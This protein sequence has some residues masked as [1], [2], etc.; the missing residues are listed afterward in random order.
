MKKIFTFV[1]LF[2][3]GLI[4][5]VLPIQGEELT[6]TYLVN[7]TFDE[8]TDLPS[9]LTALNGTTC[10]Y[11]RNGTT[12]VAS[13]V[14]TLS[15][16]AAS[17][18]RGSE[19]WF[20]SSETDSVVYF[21]TDWK[22][23]SATVGN[24]NAF[25]LYLVGSQ[26]SGLT[27]SPT[28]A[29]VILGLYLCGDDAKMHCWNKD[30]WYS[31]STDSIPVFA[32]GSLYPGFTRTASTVALCNDSNL[33]TQTNVA[34]VAGITYHVSAKINFNTKTIDSLT[35]AEKDNELLNGETLT[36]LR[37]INPTTSDLTGL[38]IVNTRSSSKGN[39][40][41][42]T[43]STSFDNLQVYSYKS[44]NSVENQ[45]T[46]KIIQSTEY[47]NLSGIKSDK[48]QKG[49]LIQVNKYTDGTTSSSKVKV[50]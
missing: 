1:G 19:T 35:V 4:T 10:I 37:F 42:V 28:N 40:A 2:L 25:C 16:S 44:T 45:N 49:F 43:Y 27:A 21:E 18:T 48:S 26:S 5:N 3:F 17:G 30:V 50:K 12:A 32:T 47:Y 23:T 13:D 20:T 46:E 31:G 24:K 38:G 41:S 36:G 7:Q 39:G 8:L 34:Y 11:G 29:D 33:T 14:L 22:I 15:V 6:K 9:D